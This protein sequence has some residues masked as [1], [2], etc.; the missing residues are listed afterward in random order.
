MGKQCEV[1]GKKA[2]VGNLVSHSNIKTKR[3]FNPNLQT[4]RHQFDDG[5]VRGIVCCTR[6]IRSGAVR[7]PSPRNYV[8]AE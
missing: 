8:V 4:V 1:C 2:Q 5:T 3:R 7:K 6:C